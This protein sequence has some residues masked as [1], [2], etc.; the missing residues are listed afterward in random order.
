MPFRDHFSAQARQYAAFRPTYPPELAAFLAALA[1]GR[2]LAW[3]V[4]TG[5]GQ[6]GR[7]LAPYFDRVLATDASAAQLASA[8]PCPGVEFRAAEATDSGLDHRSC[9]LVTVAQA[10]HWLD[11]PR[12]YGEVRRVLKPGGVIAIWGYVLLETGNAAIDRPL[13]AFQDETVGPYWPPGREILQARYATVDFPFA[14][15]DAPPFFM[16]ARW[17]RDDLIGYVSSWSAVARCREQTGGDPLPAFA[18]EMKNVWP[19]G[20]VYDIQWPLYMLVGRASES[21]RELMD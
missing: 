12:F 14:P 1:P 18:A 4:A 19:D 15:I 3:D 16:R 2:E 13:E 20:K 6:A 21:T 11:L 10:A 5:Q 17:T 8:E 7:L 9:D